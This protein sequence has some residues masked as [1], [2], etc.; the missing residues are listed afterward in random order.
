M[1]IPFLVV[2][3]LLQS[4]FFPRGLTLS[5]VVVHKTTVEAS[6]AAVI[7]E[8]KTNPD[9]DP[10]IIIQAQTELTCSAMSLFRS[11]SSIR[12][13]MEPTTRWT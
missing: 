5:E 6:M 1:L 9:V 12:S 8:L 11:R 3:S 2:Y 13:R 4:H 7:A 10:A